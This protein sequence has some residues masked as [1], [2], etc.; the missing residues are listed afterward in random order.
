VPEPTGTYRLQLHSGFGFAAAAEQ[1]PYLARLG[2]SHLYL[3]PVLQAAA[4]SQ[5]GYDV[6]DHGRVSDELGGE[7]ALADLA[8]TAHEHG[9][10]VLVDVVPNH[11]A[12]VPPQNLNRPLW[13]VLRAGREAST[14]HWFDIDW[15]A[16][17]GRL[18]LPLLGDT[19][20][21]TLAAGELTLDELDGER[22]VRYYDHVFPLATGSSDD[23]AD[24]GDP[25]ELARLLRRQPY[26]LAGWREKDAVLNYRRFFDIDTLIAVRVEEP[27]VFEATHRL[28]LDLH[29]RGVVD[30][31]RIDHPDGLA[32]PHGYLRRLHEAT[33][34]AWVLVEK[35]REGGEALPSSWACAGTTGY[36][37]IRAVQ[38]ALVDPAATATL[39]DVWAR[40]GGE[41]D[42]G[43]VEE[44]AKR[45]AVDAMLTAEVDR[46]CRAAVAA[47]SHPDAKRLRT[48]LV[49]LLVGID[50]YRAYVRVGEPVDAESARRLRRARDRAVARRPDLADDVDVL[51]ALV[52]SWLAPPFPTRPW[53]PRPLQRAQGPGNRRSHPFPGGPRRT[54]WCGSSRPAGR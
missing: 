40:A 12:L 35:I 50:V 42:L 11:M 1:V 38:T 39:D 47:T 20:P 41:P 6:L 49:E 43:R 34:G 13:E 19:L 27:D 32:D 10:G 4:G 2:V 45:D 23:L 26:R 17:D 31:F 54:S 7:A 51:V 48:A 44:S 22:V 36:D 14:A 18:A 28:L 46:L 3:S 25:E 16:G 8:E 5:H 52:E 53:A 9:L 33:G 15:E 24:A 29:A 21:D 37:A 30:G